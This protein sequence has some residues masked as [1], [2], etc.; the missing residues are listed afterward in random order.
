ML[1]EHSTRAVTTTFKETRFK[2]KKK[3][4]YSVRLH[5]ECSLARGKFLGIQSHITLTQLL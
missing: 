3:R 2:K 1:E 5:S 4:S